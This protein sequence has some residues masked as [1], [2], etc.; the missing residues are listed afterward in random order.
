MTD[1]ADWT[2]LPNYVLLFVCVCVCVYIYIYIY[3]YIYSLKIRP[4]S[5]KVL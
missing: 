2:A 5:I 1:N 3:I 4:N